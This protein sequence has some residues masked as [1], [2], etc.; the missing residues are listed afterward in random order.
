MPETATEA[1]GGCLCGAIRYRLLGQPSVSMICHCNSCARAAGSPA[2]AWATFPRH[3]FSLVRGDPARFHSSPPVTRCFC[4]SC[5]TPLTYE[6]SERPSE[7][8]VTTRSLDNPELFPPSHHSWV[9]D[10]PGW[11]RPADGLP[12]YERGKANT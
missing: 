6:H 10:A 9:G 12:A 4:P 8:D 3:A 2:V 1:E 7:I 11:G 5:G